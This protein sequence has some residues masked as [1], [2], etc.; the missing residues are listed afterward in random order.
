[1]WRADSFEKTLMLGRIEGSRRKGWQRMRWLDGITD[2]MDMSLGKLQELVMDREAWLAEV[3]GVVKSGTR[4]SDWTELKR[5]LTGTSQLALVVR[6]LPAS[7]GDT[8]DVCL[9]PGL[10]RSPRIGN[11]NSLQYS[12]WENPM[13]RRTWQAT[14]HGVAN[15]WTQLSIHK[16]TH[17]EFCLLQAYLFFYNKEHILTPPYICGLTLY[18]PPKVLL[19]VLKLHCVLLGFSGPWNILPIS[20]SQHEILSI[21]QICLHIALYVSF[22]VTAIHTCIWIYET[23]CSWSLNSTDLNCASPYRQLLSNVSTE[24]LHYLWLVESTDAESERYNEPRIWRIWIY[25]RLIRNDFWIF[26]CEE[27][28][29]SNSC[30]FQESV[31]QS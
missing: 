4:L 30:L 3:H 27:R 8:R 19:P 15:S 21:L 18:S 16:H 9:I 31:I 25:G 20:T 17:R 13:D 2:S 5:I 12:W 29:Y 11:G 28:R 14:V 26:N 23:I 6:N 7:S 10:G 22:I 24:V 1:M